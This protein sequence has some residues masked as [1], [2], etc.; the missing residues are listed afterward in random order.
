[1]G[2]AVQL[3]TRMAFDTLAANRVEIRMDVRNERSRH[4]P[5]RLGYVWE[6]TLRNSMPD[7]EGKPRDVHIYALIPHEYRRLPW[8]GSA[9]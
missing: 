3:L 5:E 8:A 7:M 1:M 9:P 2:E 4:I 6:G